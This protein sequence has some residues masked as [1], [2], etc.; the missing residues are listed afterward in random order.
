MFCNFWGGKLIQPGRF[1][2]RL[3]ADLTSVIQLLETG[4]ITPH[5][6]ARLPLTD[7]GQ[8]LR[9]AGA[10]RPTARSC[11]CRS[12]RPEPIVALTDGKRADLAIANKKVNGLIQEYHPKGTEIPGL[13]KYL[14]PW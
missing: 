8:A 5:I 10:R 4:T 11:C 1:R 6:A 9:L 3:A 7:A 12:R 2:R 13:L 14:W